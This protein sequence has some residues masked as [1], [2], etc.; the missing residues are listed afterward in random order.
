MT[1]M[2]HAN[3]NIKIKNSDPTR[4]IS[5]INKSNKYSDRST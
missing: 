4:Y 1:E 5:G 2:K 3:E